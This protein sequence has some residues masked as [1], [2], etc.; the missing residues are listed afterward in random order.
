MAEE[1][2]GTS[3]D[4]FLPVAYKPVE[5]MVHGVSQMLQ[6]EICVW[7]FLARVRKNKGKEMPEQSWGFLVRRMFH[8]AKRLVG[9]R[10]RRH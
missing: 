4:D 8:W 5:T 2:D 6:C 10:C 7:N 9:I 1:D 3:S